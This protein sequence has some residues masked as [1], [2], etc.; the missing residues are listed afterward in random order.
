[1]FNLFGFLSKEDRAALWQWIRD[2]PPQTLLLTIIV[3]GGGYSHLFKFPATIEMAIGRLER[4]SDK[5]AAVYERDQDRDERRYQDLQRNF[6]ALVR[7]V[8][9]RGLQ[10]GR[11]VVRNQPAV[12]NAP[13]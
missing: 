7:Q 5:Q 13:L 6:E 3:L 1:M 2:Q 8:N 9:P 4:Q 11:P 12:Q 10:D